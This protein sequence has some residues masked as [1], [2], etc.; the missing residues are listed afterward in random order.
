MRAPARLAL[1]I[2]FILMLP[3]LMGAQG[4]GCAAGSRSP[5]PDISGTWSIAYADELGVEINIGGEIHQEKVGPDGG[6]VTIEYK[7]IPLTF[8]LDCTREDIVCPSEGWPAS[9]GV[10]QK[11]AEYAHQMIVTLPRQTCTGEMVDPAPD[12]CGAGT[13]NP[14]CDPVCDGEV[15]V[16]EDEAFGVIGEE[17]ESFR[18]YLG[19]GI[20]TNGLNCAM[21]S[22][23]VADA[24]LVTE[25][26]DTDAWR[27]TAMNDGEVTIGYAGG[28]LWV[29]NIDMDPEIEAAAIGASLKF[30]TAFTGQ[31]AE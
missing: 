2:G 6:Q 27:V 7:G 5:A 15:K 24:D 21:L 28:C 9:V 16:D 10:E 29:A 14:E 26:E 18:L 25:G 12:A 31:R 19:G 23:S 22:Y 11:S 8:D 20:A 3:A 17:G 13:L 1:P 30:T 4:D